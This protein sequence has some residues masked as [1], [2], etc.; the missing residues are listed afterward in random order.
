MKQYQVRLRYLDD[1]DVLIN[2]DEDQLDNAFTA[3]NTDK[4]F[5]SND[6]KTMGIWINKNKLRYIQMIASSRDETE[7]EFSE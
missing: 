7:H 3:L 2:V 6:G 5:W 1:K 4:I